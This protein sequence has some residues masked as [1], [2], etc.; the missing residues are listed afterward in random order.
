M[1]GL[2]LHLEGA[3]YRDC[4]AE[5]L[6]ELSTTTTMDTIH[7][8]HEIH[9]NISPHDLSCI[10]RHDLLRPIPILADLDGQL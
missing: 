7:E 10:I 3:D 5:R 1:V 2:C 6:G 4:R 8:A 9:E